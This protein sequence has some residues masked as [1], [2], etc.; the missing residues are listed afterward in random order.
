MSLTVF[1]FIIQAWNQ[2]K[3]IQRKY[4]IINKIISK[5]GLVYILPNIINKITVL[6]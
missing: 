1:F 3:M 5:R 2:N 4:K 6:L